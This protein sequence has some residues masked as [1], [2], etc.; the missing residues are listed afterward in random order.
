MYPAAVNPSEPSAAKTLLSG[1]LYELLSIELSVIW[2][3]GELTNACAMSGV[4]RDRDHNLSPVKPS[5]YGSPS[6]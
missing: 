4:R 3:N 6:R 2:C 5:A 1:A